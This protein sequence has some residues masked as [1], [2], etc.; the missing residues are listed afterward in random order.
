AR[1]AAAVNNGGGTLSLSCQLHEDYLAGIQVRGFRTDDSTLASGGITYF[2]MTDNGGGSYS[3][4]GINP[5]LNSHYGIEVRLTPQDATNDE[6]LHDE[7]FVIEEMELAQD[8]VAL[9][10]QDEALSGSTWAQQVRRA[11]PRAFSRQ[12]LDGVFITH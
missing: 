7:W 2:A 9:I 5:A 6:T 3:V 8:A 11:L 4:S 10:E 12:E 1:F